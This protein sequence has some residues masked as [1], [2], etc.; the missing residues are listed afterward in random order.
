MYGGTPQGPK[1][2][3]ASEKFRNCVLELPGRW[4]TEQG[5]I[6][7]TTSVLAGPRTTPRNSHESTEQRAGPGRSTGHAHGTPKKIPKTSRPVPLSLQI[8]PFSAKS[9]RPVPLCA[10]HSTAPAPA[11][12]IPCPGHTFHWRVT[13]HHGTH[14][15]SFFR[16]PQSSPGTSRPFRATTQQGQANICPFLP[17]ARTSTHSLTPIPSLTHGP[18]THGRRAAGQIWPCIQG[19]CPGTNKKSPRATP[20]QRG[21]NQ[22]DHRLP[23]RGSRG[24]PTRWLCLA[25]LGSESVFAQGARGG[26]GEC[27]RVQMFYGWQLHILVIQKP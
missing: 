11:L 13:E 1:H 16:P 6:C 5:E 15:M 2:V 17:T 9:S 12:S 7:T 3:K 25:Q 21:R 19:R 22:E 10:C 26:T 27:R 20:K 4:S 14:R 8:E 23:V 24:G 18:L